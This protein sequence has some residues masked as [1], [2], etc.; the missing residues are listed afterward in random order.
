MATTIRLQRVGRN[1]QGSFRI[2]VSDRAES[3]SGPA[4]ATLGLYNPRT[5]PSVVRLDA[6]AALHWL[7]TG[8]KPTDT[9]RSIFRKAGVWQEFQKGAEPGD[10]PEKTVTLG[11]PPGRRQT[12]PRTAR[13]AAAKP[14]EAAAKPET[15][16]EPAGEPEETGAEPEK[17]AEAPDE[18]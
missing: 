10:L 11:A 7:R 1:K 13:A 5:Q 8:A 2:V 3:R 16:E 9:V 15:A 14:A 18:A 12:S 6:A 4:I 17:A